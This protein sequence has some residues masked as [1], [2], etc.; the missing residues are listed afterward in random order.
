MSENS[1]KPQK[2]RSDFF[3]R[4]PLSIV[5]GDNIGELRF[6]GYIANAHVEHVNRIIDLNA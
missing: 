4:H 1:K 2:E 3:C 5:L 6:D